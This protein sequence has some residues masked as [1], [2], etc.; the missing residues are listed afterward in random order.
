MTANE[1]LEQIKALGKDSYKNVLFKHG[2]VEP[3]YGASIEDMK[4]LVKGIKKDYAL[5]NALYA[6]G[7]YDAMY[8]AGLIAE[9]MAMTR[10]DLQR[11]V[12]EATCPMLGENTVAWVASEGQYAVEMA[13]KWIES[14]KPAVAAAGWCTYRS[15]IAIKPDSE[16]DIPRISALLDRVQATI[17]E[18][19]NRIRYVMSSFIGA[20]GSSVASLT[21]KAIE[22]AQAVGPVTV[23]MG[24]TSC[25]TPDPIAAIEKIRLRGAIGKKRKSAKC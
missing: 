7:V 13:D 20:V 3:V 6:T 23:D 14:D 18:Q 24:D 16:L 21:D 19:P 5:S 10:E 12:E 9:D 17:H 2:I 4:K 15:L 25:K 11:W 22:V 8:L 1:I